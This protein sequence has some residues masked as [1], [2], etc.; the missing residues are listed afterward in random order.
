MQGWI[1]F[2]IRCVVMAVIAAATWHGWT[3]VTTTL[4][5]AESVA[6]NSVA[7]NS[8]AHMPHHP[9]QSAAAATL[10]LC[11]L[12]VS[13]LATLVLVKNAVCLAKDLREVKA[14]R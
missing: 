7:H 12:V 8:V 14:G 2:P 13:T 5:R 1:T 6:A 9:H 10:A 4:F 3:H 11:T